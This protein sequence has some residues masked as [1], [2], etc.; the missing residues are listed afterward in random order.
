MRSEPATGT[1]SR[2]HAAP[3][4]GYSLAPN[5]DD[6]RMKATTTSPTSAPISSVRTR[7][8]CSSRSR[9]NDAH[10][11][12]EYLRQFF[13]AGSRVS[14]NSVSRGS[15]TTE[16]LPSLGRSTD[17][18][19]ALRG[20]PIFQQGADCIHQRR[21]APAQF[22]DAVSRYLLEQLLSARQQRHQDAPSFVPPAGS[23]HVPM[24]L[25]PVDQ[26]HGAMMLQR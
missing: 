4:A 18:L 23:A 9:T 16:F 22:A 10:C 26:L 3:P 13:W 21:A 17:L 1:R 11:C 14:L 24:R 8:T 7:K 2:R 25:Q 15:L 20:A 19:V 5:R 6:T 12:D